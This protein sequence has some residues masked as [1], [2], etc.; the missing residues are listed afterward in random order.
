MKRRTRR[1]VSSC[2]FSIRQKNTGHTSPNTTAWIVYSVAKPCGTIWYVPS[3]KNSSD[4]DAI[5]R[6]FTDEKMTMRWFELSSMLS[7]SRNETSSSS[8][9]LDRFTVFNTSGIC[10]RAPLAIIDPNSIFRCAETNVFTDRFSSGQRLIVTSILRTISA[11]ESVMFASRFAT[12]SQA[13]SV[14]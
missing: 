2:S 5:L 9:L 13:G 8:M 7:W 11:G 6:I 12:P 14:F 1:K 4:D 10:T 3:A